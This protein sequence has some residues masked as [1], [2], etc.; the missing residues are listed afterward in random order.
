LEALANDRET[1][2][3]VVSDP[4]AFVKSKKDLKPGARGYRKLA[5]LSASIVAPDGALCIASCSHHMD[6]SL[7]AEQV[8]RGVADAGRSGRILHTSGAGPDHPVHPFLPES[9]YLKCLFLHLD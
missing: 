5:R 3:V 9:A 2:D 7:F 1:F 6:V 4:P 8:R